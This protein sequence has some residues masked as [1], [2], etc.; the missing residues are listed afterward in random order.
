MVWRCELA[1]SAERDAIGRVRLPVH[2]SPKYSLNQLIY[3][4]DLL[5]VRGSYHGSQET[6]SKVIGQGQR[7]VPECVRD[8]TSYEYSLMVIDGRSSRFPM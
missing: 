3:D 8:A 1:F 5:L 6:E 7:S 4:L 2:L